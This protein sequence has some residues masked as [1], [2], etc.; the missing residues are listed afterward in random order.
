MV[1]FIWILA[2]VGSLFAVATA[3]AGYMQAVPSTEVGEVVVGVAL[4]LLAIVLARRRMRAL[5][6][7]GAVAAGRTTLMVPAVISGTAIV[8]LVVA[9]VLQPG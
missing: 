4:P 3:A 7:D 8:I 6:A 2:L 5:P 9:Y 1:A